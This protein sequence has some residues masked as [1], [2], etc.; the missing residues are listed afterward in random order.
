MRKSKDAQP[1]DTP[2]VDSQPKETPEDTLVVRD[3]PR[4][5]TPPIEPSPAP[6]A[7]VATEKT[8]AGEFDKS[9]MIRTRLEKLDDVEFEKRMSAAKCHP[10]VPKYLEEWVG[11]D[12][13]VFGQDDEFE[14]LVCFET[15]LSETTHPI[16][17]GDM[18]SAPA[19]TAPAPPP[20]GPPQAAETPRPDP[21]TSL[22]AAYV[23]PRGNKTAEKTK[24]GGGEEPI[25]FA[26]VTSA[27]MAAFFSALRRSNTQVSFATTEA[28]ASQHAAPMEVEASTPATSNGTSASTAVPNVEVVAPIPPAVPMDVDQ[29]AIAPSAAA[30]QASMVTVEQSTSVPGVSVPATVPT[31]HVTPAPAAP[32]TT[33][34][35]APVTTPPAAAVTTAPAAPVTTAPDT[36]APTA[37]IPSPTPPVALAETLRSVVREVMDEGSGEPPRV[38]D[39]DKKRNRAQY[40]RYYRS[41]RSPNC[42]PIIRKQFEEANAASP[43]ECQQKPSVVSSVQGKQRGLDEQ[44]HS[45]EGDPK[46][47]YIPP[48]NLEVDDT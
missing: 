34:P 22:A 39:G 27:G 23:V 48:W 46:P 47:F 2:L 3:T 21:A 19:V 28:D 31:R 33:P 17:L 7:P 42:P 35:A 37:A 20:H 38:D 32:V 26:P 25:K 9:D 45:V 14:E 18:P 29:T 15:W 13:Y 24:A 11:V 12:D 41:L 4:A 8:N 6:T 16:P 36:T 10:L 44:H 43:A 1:R 40:M 5:D 30:P